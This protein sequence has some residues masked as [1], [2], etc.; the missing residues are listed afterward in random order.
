MQQIKAFITCIGN[1]TL[2][3]RIPCNSDQSPLN[4]DDMQQNKAFLACIGNSTLIRRTLR[5]TDVN[6]QV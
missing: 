1:S 4:I 3:H 5:I 2:I 6:L